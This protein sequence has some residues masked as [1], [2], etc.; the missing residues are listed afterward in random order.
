MYLLRNSARDL[1]RRS[2]LSRSVTF[3]LFAMALALL[4]EAVT[5]TLTNLAPTFG[6][7]QAFIT[8]S[9]NYLEVV[10]WHSVVVIVPMFVVWAWLLSRCRFSPSSVFLLFGINGVLA[11]LLIGGPA[12]LMAPFWI[13]IY[14]LMIFLPAYS[15]CQD[16]EVRSPRWYHYPEAIVGCLLASAAVAAVVNLLSPHLPHFGS[17]LAFPRKG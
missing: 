2:P 16:I 5:T 9:R 14:G 4:E 10:C 6:S 7:S 3:V 13:F 15:F 8:A 1:V 11:E 17:T 12:L